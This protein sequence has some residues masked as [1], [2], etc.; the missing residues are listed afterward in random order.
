MRYAIALAASMLLA[1]QAIADDLEDKVRACRLKTVAA[2]RLE[3]L[4]AIP[5]PEAPLVTDPA[6][7]WVIDE[8]K[9]PLD[10]SPTIVASVPSRENARVFL[11]VRCRERRTELFI[12][13]PSP[14]DFNR[15]FPVAYR[16]GTSPAVQASWSMSTDSR[17]MFAPG[18]ST[19]S[20]IRSLPEDG[21]FFFRVIGGVS[22]YEVTFETKGI[23]EV[24][25]RVSAACRWPAEGQRR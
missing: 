25:R 18:S 19:I 1:T 11:M 3:C 12:S 13:T 22:Q 8:A 7:A 5:L 15:Q 9:S 16:V 23:Q 4:D 17:G 24:R 20:L 10:D 14:I 21:R 2:E 6:G